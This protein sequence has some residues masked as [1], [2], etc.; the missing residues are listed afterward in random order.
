MDEYD[1]ELQ[2]GE[3]TRHP[4]GYDFDDTMYD[5]KRALMKMFDIFQRRSNMSKM[6]GWLSLRVHTNEIVHGPK[7][8]Y[9]QIK[10]FHSMVDVNNVLSQSSC[11]PL[12]L[13]RITGSIKLNHHDDL[14]LYLIQDEGDKEHSNSNILKTNDSVVSGDK[15][16]NE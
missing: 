16:A 3:N 11:D 10:K 13:K 5:K 4:I 14:D 2:N 6:D 15:E 1:N 12:K 8:K 7:S 9:K